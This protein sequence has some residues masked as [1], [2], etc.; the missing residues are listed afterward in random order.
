MGLAG[1]ANGVNTL[2]QF[3]N[4]KFDDVAWPEGPAN[5]KKVFVRMAI[6]QY[7]AQNGLCRSNERGIIVAARVC[8]PDAAEGAPRKGKHQGDESVE[9]QY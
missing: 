8:L 5:G 6:K 9:Q 4:L 3:A 7:K 1:E 2:K